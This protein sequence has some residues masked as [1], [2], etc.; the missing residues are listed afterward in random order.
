MNWEQAVQA[1]REGHTV[2][3][4]S[5]HKKELIREADES[6]PGI[7]GAPI[8]FVCGESARLMHAWTVDDRP[9]LVFMGY[10]S[11]CLFVP[12]DE[13]RTA[14]DWVIDPPKISNEEAWGLI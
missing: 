5:H 7:Q 3:R 4:L 6:L 10:P 1:M 12:D 9:A 11:R 8:Y 2:S 14:T 13:H